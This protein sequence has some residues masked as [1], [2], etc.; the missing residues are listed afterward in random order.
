MNIK[1]S[2]TRIVVE[3]GFSLV[4]SQFRYGEKK[5]P[6]QTGLSAIGAYC[7]ITGFLTNCQTCLHRRNQMSERFN[8]LVRPLTLV[9]YLHDY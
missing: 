6:H 1:I 2:S 5:S 3:W 4:R 8:N 9:E 7:I